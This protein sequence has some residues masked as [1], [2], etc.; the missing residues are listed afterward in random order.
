MLTSSNICF[1]GWRKTG[2][3]VY[4]ENS[5][6]ILKSIYHVTF[7]AEELHNPDSVWMEQ[8]FSLRTSQTFCARFSGPP[9]NRYDE[10]SS[11]PSFRMWLQSDHFPGGLTMPCFKRFCG[12]SDPGLV[13]C[14][15]SS[16]HRATRTYSRF[17]TLAGRLCP[18]AFQGSITIKGSL[19]WKSTRVCLTNLAR[20]TYGL[21]AAT[22]GPS[23]S[24][25]RPTVRLKCTFNNNGNLFSALPVTNCT[26]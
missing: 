15:S 18:L 17:E 21:A 9:Q 4:I 16:Q 8:I 13:A 24:R 19:E 25:F 6:Y 22:S 1:W 10:F 3:I 26:K 20:D 12:N 7:W 5:V 11:T 14:L 2:L 23:G